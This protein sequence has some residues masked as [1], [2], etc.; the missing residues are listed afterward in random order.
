MLARVELLRGNLDLVR[1]AMGRPAPLAPILRVESA[2]PREV[3]S[4]VRNL[5]E[6]ANQLA[7]EQAR[8]MRFQSEPLGRAATPADVFAVADHALA[9]TLLV[10]LELEIDATVAETIRP[11]STTPSEVFNAV[12]AAG[13]ETDNLLLR[14]T[15]PSEV[16]QLVTAAVHQAA[17]LYAMGPEG[18]YLP[19]EPA[20]EPNKDPSQV[21]TRLLRCFAL[22]RRL[23]AREGLATLEFEPASDRIPRATPSDVEDLASLLLEE[24]TH[25]RRNQPGAPEPAR[26][27]HPGRRFPS[28]VYQR[29]GLLE[30]LLERLIG[31]AAGDRPA[32][33]DGT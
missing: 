9:S 8:L 15:T 18:G 10:K 14:E 19:D 12:V 33:S 24:L 22:V 16:F 30:M 26:S 21:Y 3:Y 5:Q 11:E 4:Q 1:R 20:F 27:Y 28:H 17:S 7:F 23:A 32:A 2:Q 31:A 29:A 13:S 25:I 6:R